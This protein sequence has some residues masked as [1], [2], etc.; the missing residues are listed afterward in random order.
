[1][2]RRVYSEVLKIKNSIILW[3]TIIFAVITILCEIL[4]FMSKT[5][6]DFI[7][8]M[9]IQASLMFILMILNS[10]IIVNRAFHIEKDA[11]NFQNILTSFK[12]RKI[13][14]S[15]IFVLITYEIIAFMMAQFIGSIFVGV[16]EY[17]RIFVVSIFVQVCVSINLHIL[18][19]VKFG[20][21]SNI[22]F[23]I[24]EIILMVFSTNI[25][26]RNWH[27]FPCCY[28]Y[29]IYEYFDTLTIF[30][31]LIVMGVIMTL[32]LLNMTLTPKIKK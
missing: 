3:S 4:V 13:W 28:G 16:F 17:L 29:K 11:N 18:L 5:N 7:T 32:A 21:L 9:N 1:M 8:R 12:K 15:K 23:G 20:D 25:P 2:I 26:M 27:Y 31:W 14:I 30:R 22:I 10:V 19:Q 24:I 6:I